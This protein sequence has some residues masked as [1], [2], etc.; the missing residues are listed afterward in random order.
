LEVQA[1]LANMVR[2]FPVR[3]DDLLLNVMLVEVNNTVIYFVSHPL[4]TPTDHLETALPKLDLSTFLAAIYSTRLADELKKRPRTTLLA[5]RDAAFKRLGGLVSDHLL[6]ATSR[7]DLERVVLHHTLDGVEY[8]S[9]LVNGSARTYPTV[10]G[11]DIHIERLTNGSLRLSASG[12]WAG[13]M[14]ELY[15]QNLLTQTGVLHEISDVLIPRSVD[16]TVGKL[17]RAAKATTMLNLATKAGFEWVL[18]GTAPPADS[19]WADADVTGAGWTLLCPTDDAFKSLNLSLLFTDISL[20]RDIVSQHLVPTP[21]PASVADAQP[22]TIFEVVSN[23]RPLAFE[24]LASYSTLRS[25]SSAYGDVVFRPG[26]GPDKGTYL[27]G[28]KEA[29]GGDAEEHFAHVLS[30]GRATAGAGTGGVI[31]ID[32]LLVPFRPSWWREYGAPSVVGVI[33]VVIILAFFYGVRAVWRRDT[34]EATYEPIG[35]DFNDDDA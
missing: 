33:G 13:M 19:P 24:D 32:G 34:T 4:S 7:A 22:V 2:S 28:I 18:N 30:W 6:R 29:R 15:P 27:V 35:S 17:V 5:P 23:N 16:I 26:S 1:L 21:P 12:G 14:S 8:A 20:L 31:L 25:N 10:E 9:A 11:S 3:T